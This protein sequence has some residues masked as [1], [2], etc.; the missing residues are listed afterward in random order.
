[1]AQDIGIDLGTANIVIAINGKGV[2]LNEPS[3]IAVNKRTNEIIAIGKKAY[4]M[5]G[6]QPEYIDVIRPLECGVI[7]N[8]EMTQCLIREFVRKATGYRLLKPRIVICVP[9]FITDV[10]SRAV[11]EAAMNA[12]SRRVY[13]IQEPIAAMLGAGVN[14]S[15]ARGHLVV[16]I[17][18]GTTDVAVVSMNGVVTSRS[19]KTAGNM[20]DAAIVR[21][22][23]KRHKL[24]IGDKTAELV[25]KELTNLYDPNDDVRM[26]IGGRNLIKGLP[27]M[28][29]ISEMEVFDAIEDDVFEIVDSI[30][31]LLE[32]TPPELVGD[33]YENGI[34]LTGGGA[35]LGGLDKL[36][37]R[38]L[39][40]KC[41]IANDPTGCVARGTVAAF[42]RLD[43]LL[44]GFENVALYQYK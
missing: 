11:V 21:Y 18:G 3:V 33:I 27:E 19:I 17:G 20:L 30:R 16:D 44:D 5:I 23:Q 7:S 32:D 8:D 38:T 4:R 10:E 41:N 36:I 35:M 15:K 39:G 43:D 40:I 25:K 31:S 9:S 12:G 24:L 22:I 34:I 2:V 26:T 6:K 29:N 14:M 13:L 28:I 37:N 1:M 42:K